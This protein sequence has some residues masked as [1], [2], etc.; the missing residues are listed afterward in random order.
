MKHLLNIEVDVDDDACL[1]ANGWALIVDDILHG[2][3]ERLAWRFGATVQLRLLEAA[4]P[5][6]QQFPDLRR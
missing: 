3:D 6:A 4:T 5:Q 1:P 2:A